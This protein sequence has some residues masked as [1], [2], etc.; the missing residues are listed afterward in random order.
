MRK[1]IGLHDERQRLHSQR[2]RVCQ[3]IVMREEPCLEDPPGE[4]RDDV[5]GGSAM[6]G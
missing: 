5:A 4:L 1:R 6:L 3:A 2:L